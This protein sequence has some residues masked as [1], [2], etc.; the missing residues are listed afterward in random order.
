MQHL[1]YKELTEKKDY[2]IRILTKA[3]PGTYNKHKSDA[4]ETLLKIEAFM[5]KKTRNNELYP[6]DTR[7]TISMKELL[8]ELYVTFDDG[9]R[10]LK[11]PM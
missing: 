10:V 1:S 5:K 9:V 8:D 4:K 3:N 2:L 6:L 11:Y 7:K